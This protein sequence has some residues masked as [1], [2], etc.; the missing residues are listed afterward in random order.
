MPNTDKKSPSLLNQN[1][2]FSRAVAEAIHR[3]AE[4]LRHVQPEVAHRR[5]RGEFYMAMPGANA[6]ADSHQ[7]QRV[8]S[9]HVRIGHTGA[10]NDE[11]MIEQRA[12]SIR[13]GF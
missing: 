10:I 5:P 3:L 11:R 4:F 6:S 9:V 13:S 7:R 1:I 2:G 12:V 8:G